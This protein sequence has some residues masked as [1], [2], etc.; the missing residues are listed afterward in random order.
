[1]KVFITICIGK[2][3]LISTRFSFWSSVNRSGT[4][5]ALTRPIWS[6]S[7]KIWWHYADAHFVSNF[8]DS[9][10]TIST[11]LLTWSS[12]VDVEGRPG[13]GSSPTDIQPFL[14]RLNH[15]QHCVRLLQSSPYAWLSNWNVSV[16]FLPKCA[17]IFHTHTL[18]K[19]F[20]CHFVTNSSNSLCT[21]SVQRM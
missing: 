7:A 11:T 21:C 2:N 13:L 16:K 12:F 18:F 4:N 20:H 5:F 10:T 8:S 3:F 19:L 1:M 15:S 14:K 9:Y 17:A 6:F